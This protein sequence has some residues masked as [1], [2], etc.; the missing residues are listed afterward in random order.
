MSILHLHLHHA[1]RRHAN[2][3]ELTPGD[4]RN[5]PDKVLLI[6]GVDILFCWIIALVTAWPIGVFVGWVVG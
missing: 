3:W 6:R 1:R 4:R 5:D 2:W